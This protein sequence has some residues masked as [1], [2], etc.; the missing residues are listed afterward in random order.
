[1]ACIASLAENCY[2]SETRRE[3]HMDIEGKVERSESVLRCSG[4][5]WCDDKG[6][7]CECC[8]H[9]SNVRIASMG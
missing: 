2:V 3:S 8:E 5:R 6:K 7:I 4:E 9:D 1:M